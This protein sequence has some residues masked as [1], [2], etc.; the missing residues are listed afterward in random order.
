MHIGGG[1]H[2]ISSGTRTLHLAQILAATRT[3]PYP[4]K[5]EAAV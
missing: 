1:L 3:A 2:R 5:E 4:M